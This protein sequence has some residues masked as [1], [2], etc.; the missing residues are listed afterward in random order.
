[1]AA[2]TVTPEQ[3]DKN[4]LQRI[5]FYD[6]LRMVLS[7]WYWFALSITLCYLL[8]AFYI[9]RTPPI[10]QR[11]ATV[12]VKDT[13]K[14]GGAELTAFSDIMG[15]IGRKSVDN[16]LYIFKSRHLSE[17]V[18]KEF[19]LT[20]RYT[21]TIK[22]RTYD[23]YGQEPIL[24]KFLTASDSDDG[25]FKYRINEDGTVKIFEF[26]PDNELFSTTASLSDTVA[27]PLGDIALIPTPFAEQ[28]IDKDITVTKMPLNEVT[29]M[30][31]R[32]VNCNIASKQSSIITMTMNNEVP[33][34]AEDVINGIIVAYDNDAIND[35]RA[36]SDLTNKFIIERLQSLGEELRLADEQIATYKQDNNI[37]N[38]ETEATLSA[39]EIIRLNQ[40]ELSL[41]ANIEMAN[42]ILDYVRNDRSGEGLIPASTVSLSG[43]SAA[44]A[45]QIDSYNSTL[46][47]YR[48]LKSEASGSNPV[49]VN[50]AADIASLRGSIITSLESHIEG[51]KLQIEHL[52]RE[53]LVANS[54]MSNSPS[55]EKEML[56]FA[57]QQKVKEELYI[58]LLTKLEENALTGATA[59]SNARVIDHAYGSNR[60]IS[61]NRMLI[62]LI[63][64]FFGAVIPY[65]IL[66]LNEV[67]NTKVR[68][69]REIEKIISV[70]FLGDIPRFTG[71][72]EN[73]I[74]VKEEGRDPIS[75]AFRI[76]RTNM[77]FMSV[78]KKLQVLM[79]TSSIPHSGKTFVST[80]MA[81]TLAIS[82]KK[83]LLMDLDLR[84]RTLSKQ[85]GHRNDR[86]GF[87]SYISDKISSVDALISKSTLHD[88]LDMIY[89]GPQPPNP[90]EML[91]S[92]RVEQL[93]TE[94][95]QR[96]DY[97]I[98]DSTPAMAVADA[99]IIDRLVDLTVYVIRQGNLDRRQLPDI[100]Q[101]YVDKK[102]HDMS[103]VLNGVTQRK[104]SYGYGYGYG[105]GYS[106]ME[107][108]TPWQRRWES[109]KALF[110]KDN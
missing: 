40:E 39:N 46:M 88:N 13:R 23:L 24:V 41:E 82:G 21:T 32:A 110:S 76:L 49:V 33:K 60:P 9:H 18:V 29:E 30:Y 4:K 87:T 66:Y 103:I 51:L 85:L 80:N 93:F 102:F 100:E 69:R 106:D 5:T 77:S 107:E 1:M 20:T 38:P 61:P 6:V 104:S 28:F 96:Y 101:L 86:R 98:I 31:R 71:K 75:E 59:E 53:Q 79:F 54:R 36:I 10:Y 67:L 84:R 11:T 91:M 34:R 58:Y 83:V 109:I 37:Y 2:N 17:Q 65:V 81:V 12:L 63:A 92:N 57:R 19:D 3:Q 108:Q 95:R 22:I 45:S 26:L 47:S 90:A 52:N 44:L 73:G 56:T 64:L 68:S 94:L 89:A 99:M 48:R 74:A 25:E 27:T 14:G 55:V 8:A 15:G 72:A 78:D 70:P 50:M 35:K 105:Y 97:I 43:V 7:N 42:Y 16:E 62:Y